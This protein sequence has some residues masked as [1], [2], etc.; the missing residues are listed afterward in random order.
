MAA[1]ASCPGR[2]VNLKRGDWDMKRRLVALLVCALA[3]LCA[4]AS[5]EVAA[6]AIVLGAGSVVPGN[7]VWFGDNTGWRVLRN[8]SDSGEALL[9]R[10]KVESKTQFNEQYSDGNAWQGSTVQQWCNDLYNNWPDGPE[11]AAILPTTVVETKIFSYNNEYSPVSLNG[12][13]FFFLSAREA[14]ELFANDDDRRA[15]DS[16][17]KYQEWWLRSPTLTDNITAGFVTFS[18]Y[19]S[20]GT[21]YSSFFARPAFNLNLPSVLF[22]SAAEGGK[23]LPAEAMSFR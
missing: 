11:K 19:I 2:C 6:P 1:G 8:D 15:V 22:T 10:D 4:A 18:G 14:D 21:I 16:D 23:T 13:Y 5:A 20:P 9:I 12:E 7:A 3:L 17:G